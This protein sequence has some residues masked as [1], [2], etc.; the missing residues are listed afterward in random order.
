M[1]DFIDWILPYNGATI[2]F[3]KILEWKNMG[4]DFKQENVFDK[5]HPNYNDLQK[6]IAE[7][8]NRSDR[9][10]FTNLPGEFFER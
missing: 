8:Q 6:T 2:R 5:S 1:H 7:I 4:I 9:I 10:N 3:T